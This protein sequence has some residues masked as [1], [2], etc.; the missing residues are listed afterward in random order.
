MTWALFVYKTAP[1][2][3]RASQS[4]S[5]L[6]ASKSQQ[7][8]LYQLRCAT[9]ARTSKTRQILAH[10]SLHH[11]RYKVML[12]TLF[13]VRHFRHVIVLEVGSHVA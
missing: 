7:N 13:M 1:V 8:G 3:G 6:P 4:H 10:P 9:H 11:S 12:D 5:I 2:L